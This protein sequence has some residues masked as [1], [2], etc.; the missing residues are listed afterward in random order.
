MQSLNYHLTATMHA[1]IDECEGVSGCDQN[2]RC[3]NTDGTY[4]CTCNEGYQGD[5]FNCTGI[6]KHAGV[7]LQQ[8]APCT[9]ALKSYG[10]RMLMIPAA[11]DTGMYL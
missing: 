2:S 3:M 11:Q 9:Q 6:S 7:K 5:G 4:S 1:D 8:L 10:W